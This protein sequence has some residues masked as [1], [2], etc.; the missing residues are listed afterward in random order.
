[1]QFILFLSFIFI[2]YLRAALSVLV[3]MSFDLCTFVRTHNSGD[4]S[5]DIDVLVNNVL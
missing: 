5:I 2:H 3:Q 4:K 1:M